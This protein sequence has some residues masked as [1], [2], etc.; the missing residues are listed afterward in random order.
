MN[1]I[2]QPGTT[3]VFDLDSTVL[4][5]SFAD[6][7]VAYQDAITSGVYT[8]EELRKMEAGVPGTVTK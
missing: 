8:V 5:A 6:R 7:M 3:A 1:D 4:R 2:S